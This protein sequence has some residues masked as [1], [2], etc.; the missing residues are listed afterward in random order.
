MNIGDHHRSVGIIL[1]LS[2]RVLERRV[3]VA[4]HSGV[5]TSPEEWQLKNCIKLL[6]RLQQ[7]M[8][9]L[10]R[11]HCQKNKSLV[12]CLGG[13]VM[14]TQTQDFPSDLFRILPKL[15]PSRMG[16]QEGTVTG[17]VGL[18]V[19]TFLK[20]EVTGGE[21]EAGEIHVKNV[22]KHGADSILPIC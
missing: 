19:G 21:K 16:P 6:E 5:D 15:P 9:T 18:G 12:C 8:G 4:I 1:M 7:E 22:A 20:T 2:V 13:R 17:R 11:G 14:T 3:P 10:V